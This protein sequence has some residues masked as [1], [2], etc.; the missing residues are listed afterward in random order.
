ML[1]LLLLLDRAGELGDRG[2]LKRKG[3]GECYGYSEVFVW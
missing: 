2:T 1:Y 3:R